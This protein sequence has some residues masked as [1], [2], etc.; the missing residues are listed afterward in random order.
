MLGI[1]IYAIA[2]LQ[3]IYANNPKITKTEGYE[4]IAEEC[5][6]MAEAMV[7]KRFDYH[8]AYNEK[9]RE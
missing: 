8:K 4:A 5:Y 7:K 2:V 3:G 6:K 9:I 1:D